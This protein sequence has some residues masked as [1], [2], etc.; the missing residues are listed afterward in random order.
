MSIRWGSF[1]FHFPQKKKK[2]CVCVYVERRQQKRES[3]RSI[4]SLEYGF[5][6]DY[7]LLFGL[8]HY[9][10]LMVVW[11]IFVQIISTSNQTKRETEYSTLG[12][13]FFLYSFLCH[14]LSLVINS[15][16]ER[17]RCWERTTRNIN[18]Q[19]QQQQKNWNKEM[20]PIKYGSFEKRH[21]RI[22]MT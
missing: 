18:W 5:Q 4:Q 12:H 2:C 11:S 1:A 6:F 3:Q 19:Q 20:W 22:Q 9:L 10:L 14:S 8:V 7:I 15:Q 13:S 21:A 17:K 16:K